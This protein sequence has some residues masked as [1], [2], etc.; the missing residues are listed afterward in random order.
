VRAIE[1]AEVII[2]G[3][4]SLFTSLIR[5]CWCPKS[6][7]HQEVARAKIYVCK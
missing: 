1:E 6:H 7:R 5:T 2:I 4:G 3:P